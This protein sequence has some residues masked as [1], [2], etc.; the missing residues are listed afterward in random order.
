[1]KEMTITEKEAN[2]LFLLVESLKLSAKK[3]IP[4][5]EAALKYAPNNFSAA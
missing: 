4:L 2:S 1:M 3:A 5:L